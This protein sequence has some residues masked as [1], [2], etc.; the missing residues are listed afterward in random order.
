MTPGVRRLV[1][2]GLLAATVAGLGVPAS[3]QDL[4]CASFGSLASAGLNAD[5]T[6]S[7]WITNSERNFGA[8]ALIPTATG[9]PVDIWPEKGLRLSFSPVAALGPGG[10]HLFADI[11]GDGACRIAH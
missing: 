5:G 1:C 2:L 8:N 9:V 7:L 4:T 6:R 10:E 3:A 11:S